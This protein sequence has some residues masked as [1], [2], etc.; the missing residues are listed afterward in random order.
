MGGAQ[1]ECSLFQEEGQQSAVLMQSLMH[2]AAA[3]MGQPVLPMM[4]MGQAAGMPAQPGVPLQQVSSHICLGWNGVLL[5]MHQSEGGW[6]PSLISVSSIALMTGLSGLQP[7][8]CDA[9]MP[10]DQSFHEGARH[11]GHNIC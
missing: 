9:L 8:S 10:H 3:G 7:P 5:S 1:A 11:S 2:A 6:R 4:H